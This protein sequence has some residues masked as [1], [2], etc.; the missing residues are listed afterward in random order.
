MVTTIY[1]GNFGDAISP[2]NIV[3]DLIGDLYFNS[4]RRDR[5]SSVFV[6]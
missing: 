1:S 2:G 5:Q 6:F 3:L 4:I